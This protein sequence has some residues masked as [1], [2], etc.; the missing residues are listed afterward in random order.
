MHFRIINLNTCTKREMSHF[1]AL[2][3]FVRYPHCGK[4]SVG[5]SSLFRILNKTD[6]ECLHVS[7]RNGEAIQPSDKLMN[8]DFVS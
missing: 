8:N 2:A 1:I 5:H 6:L 4:L 7:G 3:V